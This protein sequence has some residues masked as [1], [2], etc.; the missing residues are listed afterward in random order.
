MVEDGATLIEI[1]NAATGMT[2]H[3]RHVLH[4]EPGGSLV[5]Q[6]TR[7]AELLPDSGPVTVVLGRTSLSEEPGG[8][9]RGR[10][11]A[12]GQGRRPVSCRR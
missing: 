8:A 11:G 3:A 2:R 10:T 12:G 5:D 1:A 7:A 4:G 9:D 6:A